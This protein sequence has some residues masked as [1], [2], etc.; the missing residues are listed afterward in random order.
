LRVAIH[1]FS[2][3]QALILFQR[4]DVQVQPKNKCP[5]LSSSYEQKVQNVSVG[6]NLS[7]SLVL[8]FPSIASH[9]M[10]LYLGRD[11]GSQTI[12]SQGTAGLWGLR[13]A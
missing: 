9:R 11:H 5:W 1:L 10:E 6:M 2:F 12:F 7:R 3:S 13:E 8:S 4:E